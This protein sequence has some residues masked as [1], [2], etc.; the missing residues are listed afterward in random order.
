M[1]TGALRRREL[2]YGFR[3]PGLCV[4]ARP[5]LEV[6]I[7]RA[8]PLKKAAAALLARLQHRLC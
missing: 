8:L 7:V 2:A 5:L 6:A 1:R 3:A 4:R